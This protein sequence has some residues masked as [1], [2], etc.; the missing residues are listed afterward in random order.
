[1][2]E[3]IAAAL[4]CIFAVFG[5]VASM[6]ALVFSICKSDNQNACVILDAK[7]LNKETEFIL[8]SWAQR[9]KWLGKN[10]FESIVIVDNG[11]NTESR[12]ICLKFCKE[13]PLFK[14]CTPTELLEI[15]K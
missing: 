10:S 1:M 3:I 2:W 14:I 15:F 6:K 12:E 7:E 5:F 8:L 9:A 13:N 11:L 4:L